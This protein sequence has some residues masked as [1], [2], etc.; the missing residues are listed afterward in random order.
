MEPIAVPIV[1]ILKLLLMCIKPK[2]IVP[3]MKMDTL[4]VT[5]ACDICGYKTASKE[6]LKKHTKQVHGTEEYK[7]D[8][9]GCNKSYGVRGNIYAHKK[10][11]HKVHWS[12]KFD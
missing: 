1:S 9:P 11:V 3:K 12:K 2:N 8:Y 10:R 7:C 4:F 6:Q 5:N